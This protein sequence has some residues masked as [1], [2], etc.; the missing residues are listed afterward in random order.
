M[1]FTVSTLGNLL[2]YLYLLFVGRTLGT[3]TYGVFGALLGIFYIFCLI[4][5][6]VR[7][8]IA[9]NIA[10]LKGKLGE[11]AAI[12]SIRSPLLK[13]GMV[14]FLAVLLM[15]V[16]AKSISSFFHMDNI[17]PVFL[18]GGA[19][20]SIL[21][22]FAILGFF[23]GLQLFGRL[24]LIGYLLPQA[25]KLLFAV[26]FVWAGWGLSGTIGAL[27]ASNIVAILVGA[28]PLV[29][30]M[31]SADNEIARQNIAFKS[32]IVPVLLI[33]VIISFPTSMDVIL[34][35]HFFNPQNAGIYNAVATM[36]KA[37]LFLPVAVSLVMLPMVSE[38][39]N[40]RK[41]TVRILKMSLSLAIGLSGLLVLLYWIV[42]EILIQTL[43]GTEY[44]DATSLLVWYGCAMAFFSVNYLFAQY[45]LAVGNRNG[46]LVA[47]G[48]TLLEFAAIYL[49]HQSLLG[50]TVI[51]ILGNLLLV[52]LNLFS[53]LVF[54]KKSDSSIEGTRS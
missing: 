45:N 33:G 47:I 1:L 27:L 28:L 46:L 14:G 30:I 52:V 4:G 36:G 35:T 23:Q 40:S 2:S 38:R 21:P 29:K 13:L 53:L 34:V 6:A 54:R 48:V 43:F 16:N 42:P 15:M 32:F 9:N 3:Q 8:I 19:L 26:F 39:Y 11:S 22:L 18:L 37:V 50:V 49:Y 25:F 10:S 24:A 20:L 7:I 41:D 17:L 5:D 51:L 31:T 12:K 44:L